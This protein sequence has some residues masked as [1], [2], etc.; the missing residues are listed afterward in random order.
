ML[1]DF[2]YFFSNC[3]NNC[4]APILA[5]VSPS[6]LTKTFQAPYAFSPSS[7]DIFIIA[8]LR[9][10][11]I[12]CPFTV[13]G[14][15]AAGAAEVLVDKSRTGASGAADAPLDRVD[16][17]RT[18]APAEASASGV[19]I[20]MD[21]SVPTPCDTDATPSFTPL[22]NCNILSLS[23]AASHAPFTMPS[24]M[25]LY[26]LEFA[27]L[28]TAKS[29]SNAA[30]SPD[31]IPAIALRIISASSGRTNALNP[32]VVRVHSIPG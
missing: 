27:S 32:W 5:C 14:S 17:S 4:P 15:F 6:P 10:A 3:C 21:A 25:S 29:V 20:L 31:S 11:F 2:A 26:S 19:S 23:L 18:G 16:K 12:V 8:S 30:E 24:M 9:D 22:I 7:S 13:N 28:A 1:S